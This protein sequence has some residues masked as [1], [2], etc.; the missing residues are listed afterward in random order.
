MNE[1]NQ[2]WYDNEKTHSQVCGQIFKEQTLEGVSTTYVLL[3]PRNEVAEQ[4][5]LHKGY[6]EREEKFK[7][8]FARMGWTW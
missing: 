1:L 8:L 2:L 6:Q 3:F 4:V 7:A 5:R